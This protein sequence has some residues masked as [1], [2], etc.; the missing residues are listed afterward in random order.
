MLIDYVEIEVTAGKGGDGCVSFRREKFIPKGGPDGGDGGR[1][2]HVIL[3]VD[4]NKRTL[5]DFRYKTHFKAQNGRGGM[6]ALKTG[7]DGED[8]VI[9]VPA[10]TVIKDIDTGELLGDLTESGQR[11]IVAQGGRGGKGNNYFKNSI[12]QTPRFAIPGTPGENRHISLEL[13]LIADIGIIGKPNAGKSTLLS[14]LTAARPKIAD[15]PF[16]TLE[17]NLGIMKLDEI[18]SMVL[19]DIPG[20]IEGA[21]QGRGLGDQFLKHIERTGSLIFLL[22]G[23][24]ENLKSSLTMLKKELRSYHPA[25]LKKKSMVVINKCD[26]ISPDQQKTIRRSMRIKDLIFISAVTGEGLDQLKKAFYTLRDPQT[27]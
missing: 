14:R 19:A 8:V 10:G 16:T 15:Y 18:S 17:P 7:Y 4:T 12:R 2:G 20:L 24:E 5:L 9:P 26:L 11:F 3:Q 25:L 6:G 27:D 21:H 1:G 23:Y 22:D 13:K